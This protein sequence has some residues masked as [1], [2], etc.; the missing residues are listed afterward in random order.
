MIKSVLLTRAKS[1]NSILKN[2]LKSLNYDLLE[3]S[4]IEYKLL[5]LNDS[6]ITNYSDIIITSYFAANNA[7]DAKDKLKRAWVVGES[8][9]KLLQKK[10]YE[11]MFC[12]ADA[13]GLQQKLAKTSLQKPIYLSGNNITIDMPPNIERQIFYNTYYKKDLSE[14]EIQQF[15]SGLDCIL[16]YSENCAKTLLQLLLENDLVKYLEN[17]TIV[18]IS[19]KVA[20][21]VKNHFKNVKICTDSSQMI[22]FL[23]K[24]D[25]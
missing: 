25:D 1:A 10:G 2:K 22:E 23:G 8:S 18:A 7:P 21:V 14:L 9:S 17:T 20:R 6:K 24:T 11:I 15:K 3:C 16:L 12:G 13:A 4:L 5:P 19:S